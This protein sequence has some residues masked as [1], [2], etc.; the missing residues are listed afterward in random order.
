MPRK[1]DG[2]WATGLGYSQTSSPSPDSMPPG[3]VIPP[4]M[5][6]QTTSSSPNST[7]TSWGGVHL[8]SHLK[9]FLTLILKRRGNLAAVL[10]RLVTS[11]PISSDALA[12]LVS[13][14][15]VIGRNGAGGEVTEN[16]FL[17]KL[18]DFYLGGVHLFGHLK[19]F[20][21]SSNERG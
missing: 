16:V 9:S 19:S 21:D 20:L 18:N 12:L 10:E 15:S 8:F 1:V 11:K 5:E 4:G 13:L 6:E 3:P 2:M 14:G 17:A 7:T